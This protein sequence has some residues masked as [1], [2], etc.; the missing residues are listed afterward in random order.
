L[1]KDVLGWVSMVDMDDG[2]DKL[3]HVQSQ[4]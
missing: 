1:S 2:L 4:V 3:L